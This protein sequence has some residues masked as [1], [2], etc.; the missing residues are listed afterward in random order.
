MATP[1]VKREFG[2]EAIQKIRRLTNARKRTDLNDYNLSLM[3]QIQRYLI[4]KM[5]FEINVRDEDSGFDFAYCLYTAYEEAQYCK[6]H[7]K[8]RISRRRDLKNRGQKRRL[9]II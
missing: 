7:L 1:D 5:D 3:L 2:K 6:D 8:N 4:T 9:P